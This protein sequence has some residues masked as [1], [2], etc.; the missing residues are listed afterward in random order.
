ML[1]CTVQYSSSVQENPLYFEINSATFTVD[2]DDKTPLAANM[3]V[4]VDSEDKKPVR[5]RPPPSPPPSGGSV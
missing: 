2:E 1:H 5:A 3:M 4:N